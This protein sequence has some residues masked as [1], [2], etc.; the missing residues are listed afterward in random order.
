M[1]PYS[2][3][4][5]APFGEEARKTGVLKPATPTANPSLYPTTPVPAIVVTSA[6]DNAIERMR[7]PECSA[8]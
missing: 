4:Y 5:R 3:V 7:C 1:L 6:D 2:A 8:T